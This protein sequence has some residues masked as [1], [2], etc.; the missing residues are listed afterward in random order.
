MFNGVLIQPSD[1]RGESRS[2]PLRVNHS[3]TADSFTPSIAVS[4]DGVIGVSWY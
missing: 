4:K 2:E 3:E 1:D